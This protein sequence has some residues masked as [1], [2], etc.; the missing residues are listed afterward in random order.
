MVQNDEKTCGLSKDRLESIFDSGTFAEL[1]AYARRQESESPE[2]VVCGYG[3]I[4]GKLTFAF[5]Q[6]SGRTKGVFGERSAKKIA[7]LY[8][9]AI[10]NGAPVVGVFDSAGAVVYDGVA[11]LAAYGKLISAISSA[12]GV[13]P[14]IAVVDGLC[15]GTSAVAASMFDF[16]VTIKDK[17]KMFVNPPFIVGESDG[18]QTKG[19]SA[20]EADDEAGAFAFVKE[21]LSILP[22]NNA[23]AAYVESADPMARPIN[24]LTETYDINTVISEL[25]DDGRFVALYGGYTDNMKLGF[26]SFGGV[27]SAVIATD[28]KNGGVLDVKSARAAAKLLGFCDSFGIPVVTLVDSIG[29]DVSAKAENGS[30]A[31]ELAKLAY[32]YSS[33]SNAKVTAVIGKAYG[34]AY[35]LL[36]SKSVGADMAFAIPTA[37]ISVLSPEASVA[38]VWNDRVGEKSRE[39]LESEWRET[40]A[41]ADEA[42]YLGEIDDVVE[43]AELRAR[44]CSALSMLAAKADVAP[45]RKHI[46]TPL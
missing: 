11:A 21:F 17:S 13:I 42:A 44:I 16:V 39:A 26:A 27:V 46:V 45:E 43:P 6:D 31:S 7:D 23:T 20:Y 37:E 24:S 10:K 32:A 41:S 35:T 5:L 29:L 36:G 38:F 19:Y 14:Q 4:A 1:S 3:A 22:E 8:A 15:G 12:S 33:S 9:L 30:Y 40:H 34:A 28:K 2:S 18:A 25:C